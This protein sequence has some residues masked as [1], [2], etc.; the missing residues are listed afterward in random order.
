MKKSPM[1]IFVDRGRSE[2][3]ALD[4]FLRQRREGVGRA[5]PSGLKYSAHLMQQASMAVIR[6][7]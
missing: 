1:A 5:L 2:A 6:E 7:G 3:S 4:S